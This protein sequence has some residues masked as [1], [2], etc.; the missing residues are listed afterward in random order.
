MIISRV[1]KETGSGK[2]HGRRGADKHR[3]LNEMK[4]ADLKEM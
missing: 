3:G 1:P 4:R 2:V